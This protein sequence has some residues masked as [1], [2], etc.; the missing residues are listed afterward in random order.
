ME[1]KAAKGLTA[2]DEAQAINYLKVSHLSRAIL[3]NFGGRS[4]EYRRLVL[5]ARS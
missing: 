3:L 5:N 1:V 2:V 4:L